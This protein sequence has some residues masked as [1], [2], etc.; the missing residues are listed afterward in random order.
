M[1]MS[2]AKYI[3]EKLLDIVYKG[4]DHSNIIGDVPEI[5]RQND[6]KKL[7]KLCQENY[8][9]GK[10]VFEV[11]LFSRN[12]VPRIVISGSDVNKGVRG[13]QIIATYNA[14]AIRHWD[15]QEIN[16][17]LLMQ[18]GLRISKI[19]PCEILPPKTGVRFQLSV[20]RA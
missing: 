1:D 13:K 7:A 9:N 10:P 4:E 8:K 12:S 18:V 2:L 11:A 15:I 6:M 16:D 17:N 3:A 20:D 19:R 14:Y 5:R